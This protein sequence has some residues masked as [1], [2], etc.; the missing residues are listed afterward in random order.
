MDY[1]NMK[2]IVEIY[3]WQQDASFKYLIDTLIFSVSL[4]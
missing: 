2:K 4:V 3:K 1:G